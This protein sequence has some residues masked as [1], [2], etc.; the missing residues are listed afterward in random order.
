M[1]SSDARTSV[2]SA[3]ERSVRGRTLPQIAALY[4]GDWGDRSAPAPKIPPSREVVQVGERH[5]TQEAM[6]VVALPFIASL[7][8]DMSCLPSTFIARRIPHFSET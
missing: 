6:L 3:L 5:G 4:R 2:K 1:A 8:T 7:T